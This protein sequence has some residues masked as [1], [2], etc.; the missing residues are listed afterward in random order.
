MA[1]PSSEMEHVDD[2]TPPSVRKATAVD[3]NPESQISSIDEDKEPDY[4][5][6]SN[7]SNVSAEAD[8][9]GT[10]KANTRGADSHTASGDYGYEMTEIEN[11]R[12]PSTPQD[13]EQS[14][15]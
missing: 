14:V 2:E 6:N 13:V 1:G 9:P 11:I 12:R 10:S 3:W 15:A 5:G 7:T 4:Y 8:V